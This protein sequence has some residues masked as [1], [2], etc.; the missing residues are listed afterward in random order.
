MTTSGSFFTFFRPTYRR[1]GNPRPTT[2]R[3]VPMVPRTPW[4]LFFK[5]QIEYNIQRKDKQ[6]SKGTTQLLVAY[7]S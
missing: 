7:M 5:K 1:I 4:K 6:W 2:I 3:R